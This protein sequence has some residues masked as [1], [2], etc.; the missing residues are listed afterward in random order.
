MSKSSIFSGLRSNVFAGFVVSLIAMP[1][2]LGLAIASGFPPIA[3][4]IASVVGG[5]MVAVLGGSYVTIAGPGNGLVVVLLGAVTVLGEGDMQAGYLYALAAVILSGVLLLLFGFLRFGSLS[6]FFPATAIQGM[7]SAIGITI[8]LKQLYVMFGDLET[9]GAA[10]ELLL[11]IPKLIQS[12]F[13]D[14]STGQWY[15]AGIGVV[16][17]LIM[18]FYS[19]IRSRFFHLVPAPMWVVL[20]ALGFD[21]YFSLVGG[22]N[23]ISKSL[24]ISLPENLLGGVPTPN[25]SKLNQPAFWGVVISITLIS[26]IESLLSIKAVDKL[27]PQKR[28]SNTNKDMKALGLATIVSGFL[29]GMNVVT[30][31]ARSSV[32]VN[33]QASNRSANFFHA[34]F[35]FIMVLVFQDQLRR[36]PLT[37]LAAILVYTGYKLAAPAIFVRMYQ[38]GKEQLLVFLTTLISTLL[39]DLITGILIGLLATFVVHVLLNKA[40][41]LFSRNLLK[42]NVLMYKENE[43]QNYYVGIIHFCTFLNFYKLKSKLDK[44]P[45]DERAVVDFSLCSF[46]DHTVQESLQNYE[47]LFERKGGG[48]EIIGLDIHETDSSHPFAVRT[49]RPMKKL[50]VFGG[51]RTKRQLQLEALAHEKGW[52][53]KEATKSQKR[54]LRD[55]PVYQTTSVERVYNLIE[56]PKKRL[57]LCDIHYSEGA[58]IAKENIQTT[59]L[60]VQLDKEIPVFSFDRE[61]LLEKLSHLAG[62]HDIDFPEYPEF[63]HDFYV[64]GNDPQKVR[65]FFN[66]KMVSFFSAYG[67]YHIMSN[68]K[69]L[70][71]RQF[72]RPATPA[73][74]AAMI[75]FGLALKEKI[76]G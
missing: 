7:L 58:F 69:E 39:T 56:G 18:V 40:F 43:T 41:W 73:E 24:L 65:A 3:G 46:V 50:R 16:S 14:G 22:E 57:S 6:D 13:T 19:K 31:I 17:L 2:A 38:I 37:S 4:I 51:G 68:G 1:L 27:D 64:Q 48:L 15:A 20:L 35:L 67:F 76:D 34:A 59:L 54:M 47:E 28:R 61:L 21:A 36:I 33:N 63:S 74:A 5:V 9:K 23:P 32:N 70:L 12:L 26:S 45:Q 72:L 44:I 66:A 53:Y 75:E 30:V 42:P 52:A 29:G 60:R 55:H 71:V 25:F 11:G 10:F 62:I 8:L 49:L